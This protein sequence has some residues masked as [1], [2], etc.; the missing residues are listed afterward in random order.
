MRAQYGA[1]QLKMSN[2]LFRFVVG[3]C[4]RNLI[5]SEKSNAKTGGVEQKEERDV[6]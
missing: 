3:D 4:Q 1:V 5:S 6:F 2:K